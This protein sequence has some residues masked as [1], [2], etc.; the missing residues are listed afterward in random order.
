MS[1]ENKRMPAFPHGNKDTVNGMDKREYFVSK[2]PS[3]IPSFFKHKSNKEPNKPKHWSDF[4]DSDP[5]KPILKDWHQDSCYDLIG[6]GKWYQESWEKYYEEMDKWKTK[7]SE[8]RY[9]QW[10]LYY[11]D[12]I[13]LYLEHQPF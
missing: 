5:L 9:F 2:A 7:D 10:R 13:L 6:E 8:M 1:I 4:L 11:A 3:A 12:M